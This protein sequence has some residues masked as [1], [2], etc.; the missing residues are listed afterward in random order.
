MK[1]LFV[2]YLGGKLD[3][4]RMGEDH[5][6]VVVVADDCAGA[7][8]AAKEKWQGLGSAHVDAV[9]ELTVVDGY[10]VDLTLV[11]VGDLAPFDSTWEP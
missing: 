11:G 8:K 1:K 3:E 2:V 10:R 9:R 6:V 5:E 4:S 7:R